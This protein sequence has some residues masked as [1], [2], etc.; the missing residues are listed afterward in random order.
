M[1][2]SCRHQR[3]VTQVPPVSG[4]CPS[5]VG[6]GVRG[7]SLGRKGKACRL[8]GCDPCREERLSYLGF[9]LNLY[10]NLNSKFKFES[11]QISPKRNQIKSN[12][13]H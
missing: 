5:A 8:V 12:F 4:C 9:L 6:G 2:T 11:T 3:D 7:P 13:S 1:A 10:S